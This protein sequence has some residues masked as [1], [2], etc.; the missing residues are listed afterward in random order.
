MTET[1]W[2]YFA[3]GV[4][5]VISLAA[6]RNEILPPAEGGG[7]ALGDSGI[8]FP[9]GSLQTTAAGG[10]PRPLYYL[11][12]GGFTGAEATTACAEGFHFASVFEIIDP[13]NLRYDATRGATAP[14]SG[15]GPP[16]VTPGWIRTGDI[17]YESPTVGL[18]NCG[19]IDGDP[20]SSLDAADRGTYLWLEDPLTADWNAPASKISPWSADT[21]PCNIPFAVWCVE[22]FVGAAVTAL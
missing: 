9:D 20:W 2:L 12:V 16:Q 22:D 8:I 14:D 1:R 21:A 18:A 5:T 10:D 4:A 11:A 7:T 13:S 17:A 3:L 6:V 15:S 19:I